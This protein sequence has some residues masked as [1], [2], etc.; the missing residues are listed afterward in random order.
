MI[1]TVIFDMDGV[2]AD[3][4]PLHEKARNVLLTDLKLDVETI[5]PRA[6]GRSKRTFWG[7]VVSRYALPYTADEL[8][9]REFD[10]LM[11]IAERS[12]LRPSEGLRDL[13]VFLRNR[14]IRTA[15]A[16]SSDRNY[17]EH[18][19]RLTG[20]REYFDAVACGDEVAHAKPAPDVYLRALALCGAAANETLAVED[21]DTGAKAAAAAGIP[22][23]GYDAAP[24]AKLQQTYAQC[25][26][27]AHR[28]CEIADIVQRADG[29]RPSV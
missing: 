29:A 19:L 3:T 27:R 18:I 15:V 6:I 4:E 25:T 23:I 2:I 14:N 28:M 20:L 21:S 22:C 11:D 9:V 1:R 13:L 10:V 12:A 16:S 8:T 17:V 7:E 5:S 24:Y 26:Y